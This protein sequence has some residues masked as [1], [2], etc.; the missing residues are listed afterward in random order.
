MGEKRVKVKV[1]ENIVDF[2]AIKKEDKSI[3]DLLTER[4][5]GNFGKKTAQIELEFL[6]PDS[7]ITVVSVDS[8]WRTG[9]VDA[10]TFIADDEQEVD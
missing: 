9:T 3:R 1:K 4:L 5:Y 10:T 6:Y 7:I 2:V 8:K